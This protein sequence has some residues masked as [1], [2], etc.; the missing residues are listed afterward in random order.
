MKSEI[1]RLTDLVSSLLEVTRGEGDPLARK[2]ET[3]RIA[4]LL[5]EIAADCRIEAD[6]RQCRV[7]LDAAAT[8]RV[9][10]DREL[11]RRAFEN[12]VRNGIRYTPDGCQL[13]IKLEVTGQVARVLVRDYGEGVPE[14]DLSKLCQPFFRVDDSRNG[15][16]GG[17]GLGLA[18]AHRAIALHSG[19]LQMENAHPGLRVWIEVPLS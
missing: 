2:Q 8:P 15:S 14:E 1:N 5:Q 4:D 16:T 17:V 18:I 10:G 13:D 9:C 11:L 19:S 3:V 6:A 12:V 7:V